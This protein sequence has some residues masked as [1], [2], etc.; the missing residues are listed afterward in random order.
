[1]YSILRMGKLEV[2]EVVDL[3]TAR[4]GEARIMKDIRRVRGG[5]GTFFDKSV[6]AALT[7]IEQWCQLMNLMKQPG[8]LGNVLQRK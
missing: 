2:S 1:M 8:A 3:A 6:S 4:R 5:F 7:D